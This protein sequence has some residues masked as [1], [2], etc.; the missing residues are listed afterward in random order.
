VAAGRNKTANT[1]I[2]ETSIQFFTTAAQE[3]NRKDA[4]IFREQISKLYENLQ[5]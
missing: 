2:I 5:S 1:Y 4:K 3:S